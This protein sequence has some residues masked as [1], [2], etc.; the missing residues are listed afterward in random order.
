M[1]R[2]WRAS[3]GRPVLTALRKDAAKTERR[4]LPAHIAYHMLFGFHGGGPDGSGD[5]VVSLA[6]QLRPEA[7]EEART[8]RGYD[9]DHT[10]ILRSAAV[11]AQLNAILAEVR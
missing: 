8:I 9:E 1:L 3:P 11:A 2:N 6:S 5:G 10:S 4:R 7:Q